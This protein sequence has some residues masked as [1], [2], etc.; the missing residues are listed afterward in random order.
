MLDKVE[1]QKELMKKI[2]DDDIKGNKKVAIE[3]DCKPIFNMDLS[4]YGEEIID[5]DFQKLQNKLDN[6]TK[7][8]ESI[9]VHKFNYQITSAALFVVISSIGIAGYWIRREYIPLISSI[10]L[11]LFAAPIFAMAGLE[12]TYTFLSIDFCS[13]IG[14]SIISGITP[15]ED[16]GLGSYLSCPSKET[17]RTL[18]TAIYQYMI[19]FDT[20]YNYVK[21]TLENNTF[22]DMLKIGNDKR[23]N[24]YFMELRENLTLLN[25][26]SENPEEEKRNNQTRDNM[27]HGVSLFI[28]LNYI[29]AGL[30]SMT[31]C[32]T[33][34]NIINYI[35]ENYCYENHG[36]MFRNILFSI[37]TGLGFIITSAGINKLIIV[38][39]NRYSR[40]LRGK[41]EFNTDIINE[42]DDY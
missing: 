8:L 5:K 38:M 3:K 12:T 37:L 13:T 22:F 16:T 42:D 39:R 19:D 32:F 24:T 4:L 25:L 36:Y 11:L 27:I 6:F 40:A 1:E 15:S 35:E 18:S 14:N 23:N 41:K 28:D 31:S 17:M 29:L 20:I 7:D 2:Y 30:L 33:A 10:L 9:Q 26:T 21:F 34:K